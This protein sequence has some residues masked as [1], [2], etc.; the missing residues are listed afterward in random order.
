MPNRAQPPARDP[1]RPADDADWVD[2]AADAFARW[3]DHADMAALARATAILR[4]AAPRMIIDPERA[5][6]AA[7]L[8]AALLNVSITQ[9]RTDVLDE[10]ITV[11][12]RERSF[13]DEHLDP[14]SSVL[15]TSREAELLSERYYVSAG[16]ADLAAALD[17]YGRCAGFVTA[18]PQSLD[19]RDRAWYWWGYGMAHSHKAAVADQRGERVAAVE[20]LL[21]AVEAS[22]EASAFGRQI[23]GTLA[24]AQLALVE[25]DAGRR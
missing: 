23:R 13:I 22:D 6:L 14:S 2:A 8:A 18:F 10:A 20:C 4:G 15:L 19:D 7:E 24:V 3:R 17:L 16:L 12:A 9:R 5:L 25:A 21:K 11:L 1:N